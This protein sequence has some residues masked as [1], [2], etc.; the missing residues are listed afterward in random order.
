MNG[1][2]EFVQAPAGQGGFRD[3]IDGRLDLLRPF[4]RRDVPNDGDDLIFRQRR[5][6]GFIKVFPPLQNE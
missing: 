6:P 5:Q 4:S 2:V 3:A 1:T